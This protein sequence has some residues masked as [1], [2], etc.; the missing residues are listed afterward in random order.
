MFQGRSSAAIL[1]L[2]SACVIE[3]PATGEEAQEIVGGTA[4]QITSVPWQVS[5]Q[6]AGGSHFCG[7]SIV[8]PTWI[9]TASHCVS[10]GAPGRI[11]AGISKLSLS[12][13]GQIRTVKRVVMYPGY[14]DPTAGKDAA[15]VELTSPLTL[16]G[17][18]VKAIRP[19][20]ASSPA[21]LTAPGVMTTVTGWGATAEGATTLP[22]QLQTV[23]LPIIALATA[24]AAYNMTLTP[25]QLA[26]G[27]TAGGKD[28]CQGDSGGPLVV[29][30]GGEPVLAGIVSWG[31]GCA[32][33]NIP[34]LYGRVSSFTQWA[35][36]VAGGPPTAAAGN[37]LTV[38]FG[39]R[40][41]VDG[42]ASRDAGFGTIAAYEWK[43]VGGAAVTLENATTNKV[44]FTAPSAAGTVELELTV[45]DEGGATASDR[46]TVQISRNGGG[47]TGGTGGDG[48]DDESADVV[49][50][51]STS[52]DT[53]SAFLFVVG[54]GLLLA[55]RR[56]R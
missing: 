27:V 51:C 19:V 11:V 12:A 4:T 21:A 25:D 32:R 35:D 14:T 22:D 33:P 53:G 9:L 36:T 42:S 46:I 18:S 13:Q 29:M 37:D 39:E 16:D 30:D 52:G 3:E 44:S 47:D 1:L 17:T 20:T 31:E 24:N 10:D 5:M 7:G 2:A 50:G 43:L 54:L 23:Q 41:T 8:S 6:S 34:G 49:G 26:A 45:R 48:G 40:V 56:A 15:L 38:A 55:R 28:S